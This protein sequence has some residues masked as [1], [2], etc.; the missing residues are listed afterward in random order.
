MVLFLRGRR[1]GSG[2][3][4]RRRVFCSADSKH[5]KPINLLGIIAGFFSFVNPFFAIFPKKIRTKKEAAP[6]LTNR[7]RFFIIIHIKVIGIRRRR[8]RARLRVHGGYHAEAEL[9]AAQLFR[10]ARRKAHRGRA[11]ARQ[12]DGKVNWSLSRG[13]GYHPV[14]GGVSTPRKSI[15]IN[16][17]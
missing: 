11:A 1:S 7:I 12:T 8:L 5:I 16:T 3:A 10:A 15:E 13:S 6:V 17:Y 4:A 2:G 9:F 14:G